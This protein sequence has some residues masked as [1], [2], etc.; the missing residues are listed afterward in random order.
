MASWNG[1]VFRFMT[2]LKMKRIG[3]SFLTL[4]GEHCLVGIPHR[5]KGFRERKI[6][7]DQFQKYF[8]EKYL[9]AKYYDNK[10]KGFRK[11][12]LGQKYMEEHVQILMELLRHVSYIREERVKI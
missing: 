5:S 8:K 10:R 3:F 9:S 2:A 4:M 7:W 1:N 12:K 6:S 11:L